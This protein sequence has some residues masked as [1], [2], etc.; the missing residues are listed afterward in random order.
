MNISKGDLVLVFFFCCVL[1]THSL[2]H[3]TAHKF[4]QLRAQMVSNGLLLVN[5]AFDIIMLC[6][7]HSVLSIY[8]RIQERNLG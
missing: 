3:S 7:E 8:R 5:V 2:L 6:S 4:E 1:E